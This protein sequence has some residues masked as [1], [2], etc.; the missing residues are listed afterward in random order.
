MQTV[1]GRHNQKYA[2]WNRKILFPKMGVTNHPGE[3]T[4]YM[5]YA[6]SGSESV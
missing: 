2:E 3:M 4:L 5:A 1:K 6:C